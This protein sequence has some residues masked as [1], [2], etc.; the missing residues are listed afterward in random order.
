[1]VYQKNSASRQ[2][3]DPGNTFVHLLLG[4]LLALE[5]T[6]ETVPIPLVLLAH[7]NQ[8]YSSSLCFLQTP[9]QLFCLIKR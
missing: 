7:P 2:K 1:M 9:P 3:T 6:G 8:F 4:S 5:P